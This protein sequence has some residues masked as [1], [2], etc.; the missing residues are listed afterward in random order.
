M[1]I[2]FPG[3]K[4]QWDAFN[5]TDQQMADPS[6]L[7]TMVE[8]LQW[9]GVNK[10]HPTQTERTH[11]IHISHHNIHV[12]SRKCSQDDQKAMFLDEKG[13]S[14]DVISCLSNLLQAKKKRDTVALQRT[15]HLVTENVCLTR[16]SVWHFTSASQLMCNCGHTMVQSSW[17]FRLKSH[18]SLTPF[19][20]VLSLPGR[21]HIREPHAAQVLGHF[22]VN[23]LHVVAA[24]WDQNL[25]HDRQ[26]SKPASTHL[27][28][29]HKATAGHFTLA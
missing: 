1:V 16:Y 29:L 10:D 20:S 5:L 23:L 21:H 25:L 11:Y 19:H 17:Q 24:V 27:H 18:T 22:A 26:L 2:I 6:P 13:M 28:K 4:T 9:V 8:M 7:H 12:F 14:D 15:H 3:I